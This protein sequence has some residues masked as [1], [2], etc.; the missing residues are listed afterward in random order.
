MEHE[1]LVRLDKS[2][3]WHPFTQ[4]RD[5]CDDAHDPLVIVSGSG[6]LLR[7]SRGREYIDGNS[8][9]W[10]NIHGH[11]HPSI[12]SAIE[13]QLKKIAHSSFLGFTNEPAI[14]LADALVQATPGSL[15]RVFYSDDG[16][17][18][19]ECAIKMAI[20]FWQLSGKDERCEFVSFANAY[21]GDTL[22]AATLG[23]IATFQERFSRFGFSCHC[24]AAIED[25]M[26]L[27]QAISDRVAAVCIEPLIQG[28][29]G[30][31]TWP[32]G[33][34]RALRKW[35]DRTGTLL[36]CDEVMTGFGRTGTLFAC[37]QEG[38]CPDFLALAKGL[39]GGYM[40]LAATL[41]TERIYEAFLGEF[42]ELKTFFYGHSYC[43]NLL[44]CAAALASLRLFQE[45][46][47]LAKLQP[48]IA[49]LRNLLADLQEQNPDHI[50]AIRQC[51]MIAGIDIVK[52]AGASVTFPWQDQTGAKICLAAREFG[53]LTRPIRDTVALML[54]LCATSAQIEQ[55]V[56]AIQSAL[57]VLR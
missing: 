19:I 5:W 32:K 39:T 14:L 6:V 30:M 37:E 11:C 4:M 3:L 16:S 10:T 7:D 43:G 56:A 18:A 9:I 31:Q 40:P 8:S 33:M 21:H 17:T 22:G 53:L 23:G 55:S 27:P 51:G 46:D 47:T 44:S 54:P 42:D 15:S 52:N 57:K 38:V 28:A 24:V 12:N 35:C 1:D 2:R 49:L 34:L 41:T 50:G 13:D 20:Q 29:A 26:V 48:K 36:I 25:L 45:E